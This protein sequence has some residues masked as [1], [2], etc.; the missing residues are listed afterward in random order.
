MGVVVMVARRIAEAG[1]RMRMFRSAL[2]LRF[3]LAAAANCT[4][5]ASPVS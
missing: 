4:H 1:R 3:A 2:D 5:F